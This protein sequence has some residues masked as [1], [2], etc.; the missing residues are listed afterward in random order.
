M[1]L[2]VF[3]GWLEVLVVGG[4]RELYQDIFSFC[5]A[6]NV[7]FVWL[8]SFVLIYGGVL[9]FYTFTYYN[10]LF[11]RGVRGPILPKM[12]STNIVGCG[13]GCCVNKMFAGKSFC[14]SSSLI[15]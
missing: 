1:E 13:N 15:R 2:V 4:G 12:T 9:V 11:T 5:G 10:A 6:S 7:I 3:L 14:I 8:M